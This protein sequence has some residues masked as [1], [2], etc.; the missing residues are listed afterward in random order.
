MARFLTRVSARTL[1]L[2]TVIDRAYQR[3]DRTR[4]LLVMAFASERFLTEYGRVAFD[5]ADAYRAGSSTFRTGLFLWEER[6]IRDFF[7]PPPAR[8]LVGGAGGG[9]EAFALMARGYELVAFDPAPGLAA[10]MCKAAADFAPGSFSA[11]CASY[12]D[13]PLMPS[14]A[15]FSARDLR[16]QPLF[17]GVIVGWTSFSNLITDDERVDALRLIGTLTHGPIL[18]SY[19]GRNGGAPAPPAGRLA[20][21][22]RRAS[23]RGAAMFTSA[24]GFVRLLSEEEVRDFARRAGLRVLH[25]DH[26][27][28][29]PFVILS[30]S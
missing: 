21:L 20:A 25:V 17:D 26:E 7:P 15:Q 30:A 12:A 24:I 4:S 11:H 16:T 2:T 9:R 22:R 6:A 14:T 28:E 27:G 5:S 29:F 18:V 3:F 23:K 8:I 10:S 13:L 19:F 1:K